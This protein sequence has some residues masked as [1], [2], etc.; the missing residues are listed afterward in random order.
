VP[1]AA[2]MVATLTIWAQGYD[3]TSIADLTRATGIGAPSLYAAFGD[4]RALFGEV[5]D[6]YRAGT[7]ADRAMNEEPTAR[8]GVERLLREAAG[9]YTDPSHPPGCLVL[10]AAENC[11]SA[12]VVEALRERRAAN[13]RE[14]QRL[15]QADIDV[16]ELPADAD[17]EALARYTG[18]VVR[19]MS[20]QA[21]GRGE[22]G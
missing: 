3:A 10:S 20:Q 14:I 4:K 19:G 7:F 6:A 16:G 15:I 1:P 8:R 17:A 11:A 22:Q 13:V 21:R 9:Q 5:V 18:A 12:E 2:S